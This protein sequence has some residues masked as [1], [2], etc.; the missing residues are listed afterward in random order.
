MS[1]DGAAVV[2]VDCGSSQLQLLPLLL[3]LLLLLP[4]L[5]PLLLLLLLGVRLPR[6]PAPLMS[7]I[8]KAEET[9]TPRR[10][11]RQLFS[12]VSA[13]VVEMP[14]LP[15]PP[16]LLVQLVKVM[17]LSM[18]RRWQ[19]RLPSRCLAGVSVFADVGTAFAWS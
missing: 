2:G 5:L 11:R 8:A 3:R 14:S 19:C 17:L 6:R 18:R 12:V 4:L 15:L 1:G 10:R 7:S 9:S 13:A 16:R